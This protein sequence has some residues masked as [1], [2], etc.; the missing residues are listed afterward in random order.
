MWSLYGGFSIQNLYSQCT[1]LEWYF[2]DGNG[3]CL[4]ITWTILFNIQ[5]PSLWS[6]I[7]MR[8]SWLWS[9]HF[10]VDLSIRNIKHKYHTPSGRVRNTI[11]QIRCGFQVEWHP[12]PYC[13][14]SKQP[15]WTHIYNR[16]EFRIK[17]PMAWFESEPQGADFSEIFYIKGFFDLWS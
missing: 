11:L 9:D 4:S 8:V 7:L 13:F 12:E 15:L 2:A 10:T 6:I 1:S 16:W 3:M 5:A 14:K 17:Y